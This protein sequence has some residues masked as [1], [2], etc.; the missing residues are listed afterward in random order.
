M[1]DFK[2]RETGRIATLANYFRALGKRRL[3]T[4]KKKEAYGAGTWAWILIAFIP[5]LVTAC[6]SPQAFILLLIFLFIPLAIIIGYVRGQRAKARFDEKMPDERRLRFC[7]E[8]LTRLDEIYRP[9]GL[10][11]LHVDFSEYLRPE[12]RK[13]HEE[14]QYTYSRK[15]REV[16]QDPW[17]L[18]KGALRGNVEAR[19]A[20]TEIVKR[21]VKIKAKGTYVTERIC[22]RLSLV[23]PGCGPERALEISL[24]CKALAGEYQILPRGETVGPQKVAVAFA[25]SDG[26]YNLMGQGSFSAFPSGSAS[27]IFGGGRVAE[28]L[29]AVEK[30]RGEAASPRIDAAVSRSE[31]GPNER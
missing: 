22:E 29:E 14:G 20:V 3:D 10:C 31:G 7:E 24:K 30:S 28:I 23:L 19:V 8:F 25:T 9:E 17:F 26:E 15:V 4:K 1:A 13:L 27:C 18:F 16:Y 6:I 2:L 21:K 5:C 12:K 11:R